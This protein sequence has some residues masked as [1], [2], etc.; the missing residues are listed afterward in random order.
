MTVMCMTALGK[1]IVHMQ[2]STPIFVSSSAKINLK[3]NNF[4][5]QLSSLQA[6]QLITIY[7]HATAIM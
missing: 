7:G 2:V 4:I 6:C 3:L 5:S 1:E